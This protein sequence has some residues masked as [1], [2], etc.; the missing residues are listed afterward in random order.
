MLFV[1]VGCVLY[2]YVVCCALCAVRLLLLV[3]KCSLPAGCCVLL[4]G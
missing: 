3:V 1:G 2:V 4:V